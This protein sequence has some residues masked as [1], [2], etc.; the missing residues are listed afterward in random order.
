MNDKIPNYYIKE[1]VHCMDMIKAIT[2]NKEGLETF[3]LGNIIKYLWRYSEKGD[4]KGDLTKALDYT[5][6]LIEYVL[7][8]DFSE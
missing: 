3:Y 8:K 4:I 5:E 7:T 2:S 1:G 6:R